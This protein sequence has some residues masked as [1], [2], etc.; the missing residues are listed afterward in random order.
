MDDDF[1]TPGALA[2]LFGLVGAVNRAR[3]AGVAGAPFEAAQA[4][5][6]ELAGVLGFRLAAEGG[7][8]ATADAAP[9]VALLV[10]L[11][12]EARAA[13]DWALSDRLRDRLAALGVQLEDTP[14][15][16]EWRPAAPV[17][18]PGAEPAR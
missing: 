13:R 12:D 2:A 15:G 1:G 16:T 14:G 4:R 10:E 8:R 9:F 5:L 18:E 3:D 17:P 6:V 11:R 7:A